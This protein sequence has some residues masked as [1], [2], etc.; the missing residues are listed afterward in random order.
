MSAG[1]H[2]GRRISLHKQKEQVFSEKDIQGAEGNAQ[3]PYH[4]DTR[5]ETVFKPAV[6][7]GAKILCREIGDTVSDGGKG[8]NDQIVQLYGGGVSGHDGGA[9]TVDDALDQYISYGNKALL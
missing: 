4:F 2:S 7:A 5:P 3:A 9:E 6:F 8:G 1:L